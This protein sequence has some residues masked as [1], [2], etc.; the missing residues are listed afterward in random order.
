MSQWISVAD[1]Q[2]VDRRVL[3]RQGE[4][5]IKAEVRYCAGRCTFHAV[6]QDLERELQVREW[7]AY[8]HDDPVEKEAVFQGEVGRLLWRLHQQPH[9]FGHPAYGPGQVSEALGVSYL[10]A[11]DLLNYI[12]REG[13]VQCARKFTGSYKRILLTPAGHRHIEKRIEAHQAQLERT[14]QKGERL[15]GTPPLLN[16]ETRHYLRQVAQREAERRA[17]FTDDEE[18]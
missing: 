10:Y 3:V 12:E 16:D 14:E 7:Q 13:L 4:Q 2:P 17:A 8:L 15:P 18:E 9:Y 11:L 5:T 1:R 6:A